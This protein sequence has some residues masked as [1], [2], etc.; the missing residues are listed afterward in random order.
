MAE[1]SLLYRE[2][3]EACRVCACLDGEEQGCLTT[4]GIV[5]RTTNEPLRTDWLDAARDVE[6]RVDNW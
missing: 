1:R 2:N 5:T 6:T 3:I 4:K